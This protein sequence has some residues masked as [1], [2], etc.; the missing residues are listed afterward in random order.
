MATMA[1]A[2]QLASLRRAAGYDVLAT[3]GVVMVAILL[4][5]AL[6]GPW[7]AL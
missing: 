5:C 6:F 7:I 2:V 3:A 4:F 1:S